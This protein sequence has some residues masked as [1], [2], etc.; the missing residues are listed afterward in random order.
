L[1]HYVPADESAFLDL[2]GDPVVQRWSFVDYLSPPRTEQFLRTMIESID[3]GS[4][5]FV[6]V[7]DKERHEVLGHVCLN[8]KPSPAPPNSDFG[9]GDDDDDDSAD[10]SIGI[11]LKARYRGRGFGTEVMHWLITYGFRELGLRRISLTVLED[12]IPALR[13]YKKM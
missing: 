4:T 13:M 10:A 1:R 7:E 2:W 5:F 9:G 12:N 11:A 3:R 8:F 6:V